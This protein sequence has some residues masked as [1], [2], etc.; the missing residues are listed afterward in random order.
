MLESI[1]YMVSRFGHS[2]STDYEQLLHSCESFAKI[3]R[4]TIATYVLTGKLTDGPAMIQGQDYPHTKLDLIGSYTVIQK[5]VVRR[6]S[7]TKDLILGSPTSGVAFGD[8]EG[9]Y[10]VHGSGPDPQHKGHFLPVSLDVGDVWSSLYN[11]DRHNA[12]G[13]HIIVA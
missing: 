5:N 3:N 4:D 8:T 12:A 9:P 1:P 7:K 10:Y 11:F 13:G 6:S 2:Y